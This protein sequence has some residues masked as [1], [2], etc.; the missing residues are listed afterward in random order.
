MRICFSSLARIESKVLALHLTIGGYSTWRND[1]SRERQVIGCLIPWDRCKGVVGHF[2]LCYECVIEEARRK[3]CCGLRQGEIFA[4]LVSVE[5]EIRENQW[6]RGCKSE[7]RRISQISA[8]FAGC[9][10]L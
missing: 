10:D 6:E 5:E 9:V 3:T 4:N 7:D 2:R 8:G 1:S